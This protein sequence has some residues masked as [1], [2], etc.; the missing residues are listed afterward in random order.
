MSQLAPSMLFTG[1]HLSSRPVL[2]CR[3][4][5]RFPYLCCCLQTSCDFINLTDGPVNCTVIPVAVCC[6]PK[7]AKYYSYKDDDEYSNDEEQYTGDEEQYSGNEEQ[8]SEE[9]DGD[10]NEEEEQESYYPPAPAPRSSKRYGP[11]S[12]SYYDDGTSDADKPYERYGPSSK[13]YYG[14]YKKAY[15]DAS[16]GGEDDYSMTSAQKRKE[17][18]TPE[19]LSAPVKS[20][21]KKA[22]KASKADFPWLGPLMN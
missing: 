11:S 15:R 10:D 2:S 4:G 19:T 21:H 14:K 13:S 3:A 7:P 22:V 1:R 20:G 12:K 6:K 17:A 18:H 8:Y 16:S 9:A 5:C